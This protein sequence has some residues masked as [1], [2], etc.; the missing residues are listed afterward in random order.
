MIAVSVH[1]DLLLVLL[2]CKI[3]R[4]LLLRCKALWVLLLILRVPLRHLRWVA[5]WPSRTC[6]RYLRKRV[7]LRGTL[8][9]I[10][11]F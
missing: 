1:L 11:F 9:F 8:H 4:D 5:G 6:V 10:P 2:R 7:I 3:E